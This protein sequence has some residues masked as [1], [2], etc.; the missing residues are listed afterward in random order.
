M[1]QI[2]IASVTAAEVTNT[3]GRILAGGR[4]CFLVV[5][6]GLTHE[7]AVRTLRGSPAG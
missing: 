2:A 6:G 5:H 4:L 3:T 7:A 1:A